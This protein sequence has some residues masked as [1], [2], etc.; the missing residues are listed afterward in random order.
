MDKLNHRCDV[1]KGILYKECGS[2]MKE[3]FKRFRKNLPVI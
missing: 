3:F 1:T 2:I